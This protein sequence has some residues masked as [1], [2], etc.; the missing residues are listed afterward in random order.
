MFWVVLFFC[1]SFCGVHFIVIRFVALIGTPF[2][3]IP[4]LK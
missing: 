1:D 3:A 2:L 4:F